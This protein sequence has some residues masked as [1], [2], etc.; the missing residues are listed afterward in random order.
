M[1]GGAT[2]LVGLATSMGAG[3]GGG[4]ASGLSYA[5]I[6]A[7]AGSIIPG[8]GTAIGGAAGALMDT[9]G[10][11]S[12]PKTAHSYA[13]RNDQ[14]RM[15]AVGLTPR[16]G[17]RQERI[18]K[19]RQLFPNGTDWAAEGVTPEVMVQALGEYATAKPPKGWGGAA[20]GEENLASY[21]SPSGSGSTAN[22]NIVT[23][24]PNPADPPPPENSGLFDWKS[25]GVSPWLI[26]AVLVGVAWAMGR[27]GGK[28][29]K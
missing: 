29:T 17:G 16:D 3:G 19:L 8:V 7:T 24:S 1:M 6:G 4:G 25:E 13:I 28:A 11:S 10:G 5:S 14:L 2:G 20:P 9:V 12:A 22:L 15:A 26:G 27:P 21:G 18:R 23:N